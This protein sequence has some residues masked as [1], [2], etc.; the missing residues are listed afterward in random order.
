MATPTYDLIS[1]QVLGS[2]AASVTFSSIPQA[3]RDL[4]LEIVGP[5]TTATATISLQCNGD[6]ASNYSATLL[7]GNGTAASSSRTSTQTTM[8]VGFIGAD[9]S[10]TILHVQSYAATTI[11]KSVLGRSGSAANQ[12]RAGVGMWSSTAAITSLLVAVSASTFTAGCT[13][14]LWGIA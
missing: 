8:Q 7:I 2:A 6:T 5:L 10:T 1:E 12:V 3:Y 14:R 11:Y 9:V 13:F 4:V